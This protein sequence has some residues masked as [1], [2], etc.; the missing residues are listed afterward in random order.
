MAVRSVSAARLVPM[1]G[2][3]VD[4]SPAYLGL[5]DAVRLLIAD[6]RLPAGTRLPSERDLTTALGVSRSTVTRA[7]A[8]LRDRGYVTSRQGSG[9]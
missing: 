5:A 6:G 8:H 2:A 3:A 7:Y 1:L 9:S 4:Q